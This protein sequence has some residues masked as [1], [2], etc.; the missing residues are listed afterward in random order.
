M[1][2]AAERRAALTAAINRWHGVVNDYTF[3]KPTET[4]CDE[5]D[6]ALEAVLVATGVTTPNDVIESFYWNA[7]E[8][9]L[10]P[11]VVTTD[12]EEILIDY[13]GNVTRGALE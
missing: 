4:E 8:A 3:G 12:T 13:N 5:A 1:K 11:I 2:T 6:L 9:P 7:V 10:S